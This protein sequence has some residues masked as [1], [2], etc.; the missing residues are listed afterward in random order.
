MSFRFPCSWSF[1]I[2]GI[3]KILTARTLTAIAFLLVSSSPAFSW[4]PPFPLPQLGKKTGEP[5]KATVEENGINEIYPWKFTGRMWV[6]PALVRV[7]PEVKTA[8]SPSSIFVLS[9]FGWTIGG[10]VALECKRF[11]SL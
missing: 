8:P 2:A 6:R 11:W 10:V 3:P 9:L 1:S 4:T 7:S 5:K